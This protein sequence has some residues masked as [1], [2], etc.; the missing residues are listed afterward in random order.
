MVSVENTT[1][2][3]VFIAL[4]YQ[5]VPETLDEGLKDIEKWLTNIQSH[6][7]WQFCFYPEYGKKQG[8]LH[9]HG[10]VHISQGEE[11]R[12]YQHLGQWAQKY[13]FY[14]ITECNGNPEDFALNQM[15]YMKKQYHVWNIKIDNFYL[16]NKLNTQLTKNMKS[17]G[18]LKWLK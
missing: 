15:H 8:R 16:Q 13:G 4:T 1:K 12:L 17:L 6:T 10:V 18:I 9:Y 5:Y 14:H 2:T 11:P 3:P 7:D